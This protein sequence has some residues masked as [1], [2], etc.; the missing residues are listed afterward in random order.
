MQA[1]SCW[2]TLSVFTWETRSFRGAPPT[3]ESPHETPIR[4]R[5]APACAASAWSQSR[6]GTA[7]MESSQARWCPLSFRVPSLA[8]TLL[9]LKPPQANPH[10]FST[11][12]WKCSEAPGPE[13]G[14]AP[15][16][17]LQS[18]PGPGRCAQFRDAVPSCALSQT[19]RG[20]QP[21]PSGTRSQSVPPTHTPRREQPPP[22]PS[23]D[24]APGSRRP[25]GREEPRS[26]KWLTCAPTRR[27][28]RAVSARPADVINRQ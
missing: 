16:S 24:P 1:R 13:S 21:Q 23:C 27:G 26:S 7:Q 22:Q 2:Q 28:N 3:A 14:S 25:A 4:A 5:H 11:R 19:G 15:A 6:D 12:C 8:T 10:L 20:R 17:G 9:R 18:R